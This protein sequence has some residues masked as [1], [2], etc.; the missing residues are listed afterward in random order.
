MLEI[1]YEFKKGEYITDCKFMPNIKVGSQ[2]C[3]ICRCCIQ[4]FLMQSD[5]SSG[6]ILCNI[7]SFRNI[8]D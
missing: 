7:D 1:K 3:V 6:T 5:N 8:E 4:N 2:F